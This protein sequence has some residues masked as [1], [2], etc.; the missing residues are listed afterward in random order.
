MQMMAHIFRYESLTP[1]QQCSPVPQVGFV[2]FTCQRLLLHL[3]FNFFCVRLHV[4]CKDTFPQMKLED[5]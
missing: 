2:S 4:I 1:S 5:K 3:L